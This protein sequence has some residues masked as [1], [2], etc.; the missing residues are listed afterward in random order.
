MKRTTFVSRGNCYYV[1]MKAVLWTLSWVFIR[2]TVDEKLTEIENANNWPRMLQINWWERNLLTSAR[3][4]NIVVNQFFEFLIKHDENSLLTSSGLI[5]PST[6]CKN[7]YLFHLPIYEDTS[8]QENIVCFIIKNIDKGHRAVRRKMN[9]ILSK[10]AQIKKL[11]T[12]KEI[13]QTMF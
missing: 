5:I 6:Y 10:S 12:F 1:L 4:R 3:R 8:I 9:L 7:N 13:L 2:R 11:N